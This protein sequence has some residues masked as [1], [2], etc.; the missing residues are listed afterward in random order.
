MALDSDKQPWLQISLYRQTPITGIILQGR[1]DKDQW[2]TS[3][4]VQISLDG[5]AWNYVPGI[6]INGRAVEQEVKIGCFYY[7]QNIN[8]LTILPSHDKTD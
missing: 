5:A 1:D 8:C 2:V 3:Y 7:I 6:D 4:K